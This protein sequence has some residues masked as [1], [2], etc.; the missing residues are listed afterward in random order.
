MGYHK[1]VLLKEALAYLKVRS[2]GKYLDATVG[3]GGYSL[4]ILQKGGKVIGIDADQESLN[5]T[6]ARFA[7]EGIASINFELIKGNFRD[8]AELVNTKRFDGIVF[9]LG[10][11]SNQLDDASRGFSFSKPAPLD[12]RMDQDL[13]V[14]ALDL[15]NGLNVREL[16]KL[17][18]LYGEFRD[19]RVIKAI[20]SS[21][22]KKMITDTEELANLIEGV[23]GKK[24]GK[25][26]PATL[27]FQ[28]LRIAVNDEI[29][30][31]KTG[32]PQAIE[33]LSPGGRLVVV[34]FHSLEDRVVKESF[35][36]AKLRGVGVMV[37]D[38]IRPTL[39]EIGENPRSRSAKM[40]IFEKTNQ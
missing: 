30:S 13:G 12:M 19:K 15:I 18:A 25:I 1:S 37:D 20:I 29:N 34:S 35:N 28:A 14:K 38:L 40:R 6:K 3:D 27:V 32:L 22:E 4:G 23:T 39:E 17:F 36:E 2:A 5:R 31:L 26:H 33:A 24:P 10:V 21:R 11:S 9:D 16:E 7:K 8:L